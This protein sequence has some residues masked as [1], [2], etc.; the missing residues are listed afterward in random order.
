[1]K[2]RIKSI[3]LLLL[4]V[5]T[6]SCSVKGSVKVSEFNQ[7]ADVLTSNITVVNWN[8]RKGFDSQFTEDL[9]HLIKH[10]KPDILLMQEVHMDLLQNEEMSGYFANSW[11]Y[12]WPGGATM[13][14]VTLSRAAPIKV[15]P[16]PSKYREFFV[17]S[18]KV[19]L[20]TEYLLVFKLTIK[21]F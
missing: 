12:P 3:I 4:L 18:P 8:A 7:S 21:I 10:H 17:T 11:K 1:M 16:V 5:L 14:V 6:V 15:L 20:I 13:G 2:S 19:S 9:L